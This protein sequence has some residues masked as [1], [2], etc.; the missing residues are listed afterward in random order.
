MRLL[1]LKK[2]AVW[3]H[4]GTRL[5]TLN[6]V[7]LPPMTTACFASI[8]SDSVTPEKREMLWALA[9]EDKELGGGEKE[10]L[11]SLLLMYLHV[12]AG[13]GEQLGCTNRIRHSIRTADAPP[14]RQAVRCIP[15][16]RRKKEQDLL[17]NMLQK[18]IIKPSISP[19][20]APIVLVR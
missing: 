3:I 10:K 13:P 11:F 18:D 12:F 19:W 2:E 6:P 14:I 17:G 9:D 5:A 4:E 15:P 20:A 1:N 8:T 7:E 16:L